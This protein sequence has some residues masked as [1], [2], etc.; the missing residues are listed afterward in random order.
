MFPSGSEIYFPLAAHGIMISQS[1]CWRW[2]MA[3]SP[4]DPLQYLA[5]KGHHPLSPVPNA[6]PP[7]TPAILHDKRRGTINDSWS[8]TEGSSLQLFDLD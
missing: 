8:P 5:D 6:H 7:P 1:L 4:W 3:S 2:R